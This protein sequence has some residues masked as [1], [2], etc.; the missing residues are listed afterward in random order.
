MAELFLARR[1][2]RR[3]YLNKINWRLTDAENPFES[4][5]A[6]FVKRFRLTKYAAIALIN[7]LRPVVSLGNNGYSLEI[8]VRHL[9]SFD[10]FIYILF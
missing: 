8:Y 7:E 5:E 1:I 10:S 3:R 6:E 4:S 2:R 9:Y